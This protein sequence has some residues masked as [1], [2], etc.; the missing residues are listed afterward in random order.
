MAQ[1]APAASATL[2]AGDAPPRPPWHIDVNRASQAELE[3][4]RG[5]GPQLS[6]RILQARAA[7]PF[8]DWSDLVVRVPGLGPHTARRL[9]AAGLRLDGQPLAP[10]GETAPSA[11]GAPSQPKNRSTS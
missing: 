4:V 7:G 6:E 10:A 9:S 5:I 3:M 2:P 8:R 11:G 1:G